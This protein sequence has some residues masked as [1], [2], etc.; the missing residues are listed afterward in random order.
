M[1]VDSVFY[2]I[3]I[4]R[5]FLPFTIL[6]VLNGVIGTFTVHPSALEWADFQCRYV[7]VGCHMT[8]VPKQL[9]EYC[10]HRF[11]WSTKTVA[12]TS[13]LRWAQVFWKV[14]DFLQYSNKLVLGEETTGVRWHILSI[15]PHPRVNISYEINTPGC[16]FPNV[17]FTPSLKCFISF[18]PSV[19]LLIG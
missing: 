14:T 4:E 8:T 15:N 5:R 19:V 3:H 17:I 10:S 18:M 11:G 9:W 13:K 16:W 12:T 7:V 2:D 1:K 6:V